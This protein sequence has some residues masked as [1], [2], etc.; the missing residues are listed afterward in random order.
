MSG[1]DYHIIK[2]ASQVL[3]NARKINHHRDRG[4]STQRFGSLPPPRFVALVMPL[5]LVR[6]REHLAAC[7]AG[8]ASY[9]AAAVCCCC[10]LA[11]DGGAV[12]PEMVGL[13]ERP[14]AQLARE[15]FGAVGQLVLLEGSQLKNGS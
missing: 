7:L 14:V 13:R 10:C 5:E 8:V 2:G 11:V 6:E 4:R 1:G 3:V 9:I 15:G 12:V